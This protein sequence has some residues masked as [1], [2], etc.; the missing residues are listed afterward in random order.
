MLNNLQ[1]SAVLPMPGR[2]ANS[3]AGMCCSVALIFLC[4]H[5]KLT[6]PVSG[7][8]NW[9]LWV[10][11]LCVMG[12]QHLSHWW[13]AAGN[14]LCG[15]TLQVQLEILIVEGCIWFIFSPFSCFSC[16]IETRVGEEKLF[17]NAFF[18]YLH[19]AFSLLVSVE[20]T[21]LILAFK[22]RAVQECFN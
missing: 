18:F 10:S 19:E 15:T 7:A 21:A 13:S 5:T 3:C 11:K 22:N 4:S 1:V 6:F 20:I 14:G 17:E 8:Q 9:F 16:I 12:W 2:N